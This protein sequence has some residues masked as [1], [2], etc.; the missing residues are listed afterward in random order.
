MASVSKRI[1]ERALRALLTAEVAMV[2]AAL[3]EILAAGAQ[4]PP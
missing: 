2:D 1:E 4:P 3:S